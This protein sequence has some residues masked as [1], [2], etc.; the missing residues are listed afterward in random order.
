MGDRIDPSF[1]T[2]LAEPSVGIKAR[3]QSTNDRH[4]KRAFIPP[5]GSFFPS[6]PPF[7]PELQ[8]VKMPCMHRKWQ[9]VN[10]C[11]T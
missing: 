2:A 8:D 9:D 4:P 7:P 1:G 3:Q 5:T 6:S 11:Y 10:T